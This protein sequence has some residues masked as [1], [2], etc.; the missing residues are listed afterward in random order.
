MLPDELK[1][2]ILLSCIFVKR[3]QHNTNDYIGICLSLNSNY[4]TETKQLF[5][6]FEKIYTSEIV[7]KGKILQQSRTNGKISFATDDFV[8]YFTSITQL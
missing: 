6:Y 2:V 3:L 4:C 8:N 7:Q 5:D 1:K